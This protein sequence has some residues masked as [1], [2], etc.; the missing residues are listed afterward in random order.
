MEGVA[1]KQSLELCP[2]M[3]RLAADDPSGG[4]GRLDT[5]A[6]GLAS[7]GRLRGGDGGGDC[8]PRRELA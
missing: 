5:R 2:R 3:A 1:V 8:G 6:L 7:G 4:D